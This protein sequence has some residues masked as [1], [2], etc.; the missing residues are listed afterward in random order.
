MS[1]WN[2]Q[3]LTKV[4]LAKSLWRKICVFQTRELTNSE[5]YKDL[6]FHEKP[7][8]FRIIFRLESDPGLS[9]F[10]MVKTEW[11]LT[12][13]WKICFSSSHSLPW[14]QNTILGYVG[15]IYVGLLNIKMFWIASVQVMFLFIAICL[16]IFTF[17]EM[18]LSFIC[19]L[20]HLKVNEQ[21]HNAII[22]MIEFHKDIK[23]YKMCEIWKRGR[24]N[25]WL[26]SAFLSFF[27]KSSDAYS[28]L[29]GGTFIW[30]SFAVACSAFVCEMVEWFKSWTLT[31]TKMGFCSFLSETSKLWQCSDC[32]WRIRTD[33]HFSGVFPMFIGQNG[34]RT[35]CTNAKPFIRRFEMVHFTDPNAKIFHPYVGWHTTATVLRWIRNDCFELG[36]IYNGK[37]EH[38]LR[39]EKNK[40]QI[41][42]LM[43]FRCWGDRTRI[44]W[45][46]EQFRLTEYKLIWFDQPSVWK[47]WI[48]DLHV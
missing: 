9:R 33:W 10:S 48:W 40:N 17:Y 13:F 25:H 14:N 32:I 28:F 35:I 42:F 34:H 29:F 36:Y 41:C 7:S 12:N 1:K 46:F 47:M 2:N 37:R 26:S 30:N 21:R 38:K 18:F 20:K 39:E 8:Q 22:E 44:S 45:C 6:Q 31:Y 3:Q 4:S 24:L 27:N 23:R 16:Y 15:E 5:P 43:L 19:R 11:S